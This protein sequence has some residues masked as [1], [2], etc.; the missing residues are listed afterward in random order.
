MPKEKLTQ[1]FIEREPFTEVGQIDYFDT[2]TPGFGL[3]IGKQSKSFFA[4]R[5]VNG[6]DERKTIGRYPVFSLEDARLLAV[7]YLQEM[8]RGSS[9]AE[10]ER[11]ERAT[12]AAANVTLQDMLDEMLRVRSKLGKV[13]VDWYTRMLTLYASDWLTKPMVGITQKMVLDRHATV[14]AEAGPGAADGLFRVVRTVWNFGKLTDD[15]KDIIGANPVDALKA[16]RRWHNLLPR[17]GHVPNHQMAV[18]YG[19]VMAEPNPTMRDFLLL[20][21]FTGMRRDNALKLKWES[22]DFE[23]RCLSVRKTKRGI[24]L[25]IPLN[26]FLY[27][28]FKN[29]YDNLR[30]NEYVFPGKG[31]GGHLVEPRKA[32]QRIETATGIKFTPHDLRRTLSSV[33]AEVGLSFVVIKKLVSHATGVRTEIT[34]DYIITTLERMRLPSQILCDRLMTL[35]GIPAL[36]ATEATEA[37]AQPEQPATEEEKA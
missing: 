21:M 10:R 22:I 3:R 29:R 15:Y 14:T 23:G 16:H 12:N 36:P 20:L 27:G 5:K 11:R 4:Q 9:P 25:L 26:S 24:H 2:V 37:T 33:G 32:I 31:D 30:E 17:D 35:C 34:E 18:W 6:K 28:L 1:K 7:D 8:K 19:A 13:T